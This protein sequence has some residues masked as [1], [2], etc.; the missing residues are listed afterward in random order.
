MLFATLLSDKIRLQ[1]K[2][3]FFVGSIL[4]DAYLES[5]D[6]K[7]TH[8]IKYIESENC[9]YFDFH[10][11]YQKYYDK[12]IIDDLYLGYY[13]HI[14]EDAFYRYYL[15]YEK[16][17][18]ERIKSYKLDVLHNDYHILNSFITQK[19]NLP[20]CID[21]PKGFDEIPLSRIT[22]FDVYGIISEYGSDLV[23]EYGG[24]TV[25]LT[26]EMLEEFVAKYVDR[27]E[28]ELRGMKNGISSLN[29]LD[30]KWEKKL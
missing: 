18:M 10:D 13:A 22:K 27:V 8:F 16:N 24:T 29:V 2:N 21:Y 26:E 30:Y 6:R 15:Y 14:V 3:R 23:E 12:V 9:L 17:F 1:D 28:D 5:N 11:F 19:Y 25:L 7:K 4:P 20:S